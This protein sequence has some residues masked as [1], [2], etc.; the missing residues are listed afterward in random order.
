[1]T[2]N[3]ILLA[4]LLIASLAPAAPAADL[5]DVGEIVRQANIATFYAGVDGRAESRMTIVDGQGRKQ[6]R[7]F[8]ILRREVA[9][10]GD[11]DFLV[12]L[13]YPADVRDTVFLVKKHVGR[14]DD[15]WLY[16]PSLD[17]VKRIVAGDKRTSF[18][19]SHFFYEDISG[20]GIE[21]DEHTLVETTATQYVVR[22]V[23]KDPR[24]VEFA[25]FTVWIDKDTM[26]PVRSEF[27]D[28]S[29]KVY[30]RVEAL[31]VETIDGHPTATKMK[32]SDLARGAYTINEIRF[33]KYDV[34]FPESVFTERSLRTPPRKWLRR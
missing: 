19:G 32:V 10:G 5:D 2:T 12:Q 1:M 28:A 30:R 6:V 34:G 7:Q 24:S 27:V 21:E 3:R 11:Q 15:R 8:T 22:N 31:E 18:V 4:A 25:E 33:I 17:L 9:D 23:P 29:G 16:L 20:R 26:L 13:S 14:D